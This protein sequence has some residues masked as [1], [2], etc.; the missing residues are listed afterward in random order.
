M[1]KLILL[2][3][4]PF[5]S[6]AQTTSSGES[7]AGEILLNG[8]VSAESNQI[9]NVADPIDAQDAA[10]K[11][12]VD[13]NV[14]SPE[15]SIGYEPELGGYVFM[16][17]ANG[18]HGLVCEIEDQGFASWYDAQNIISNPSNHSDEGQNFTDWRLP[19]RYELAQ[20][21]SQKFSIQQN[22][23]TFGIKTYWSSTQSPGNSNV[24]FTGEPYIETAW[25][26]NFSSGEQFDSYNF[27]LN[28]PF[29]VRSV[30]SF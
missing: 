25:R 9:K 1:K 10:T 23:D 15:Y 2:L 4:I 12:Y 20:M 7:D 22:G 19:T 16:I 29:Y 14:T 13:N 8:I 30:R 24:G 11:N 5:I 28:Q 21:F 3:I 17:S 18:K 6:Q 26:Q 27:T